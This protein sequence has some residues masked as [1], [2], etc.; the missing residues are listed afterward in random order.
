M[1]DSRTSIASEIKAAHTRIAEHYGLT[2]IHGAIPAP[3]YHHWNFERRAVRPLRHFVET[4]FRPD[5]VLL[6]DAG[7]GNGQ[8][9][10]LYLQLF[11]VPFV[12]GV[13]FS[14]A[15]LHMARRRLDSPEPNSRFLAVQA[16]LSD[17]SALR[18][19]SVDAVHLFGVIE[20]LDHPVL[21][22]QQLYRVLKKG[23]CMIWSVPR[24]WSLA[25]FD[26]LLFGQSPRRWG[27]QA[28][29]RDLLSVKDKL[30]FYRFFSSKDIACMLRA[31]PKAK[32]EARIPFAHF[33]VQGFPFAP[34]FKLAQRQYGYRVLDH[35]DAACKLWPW[36]G[37]EFCIVRKG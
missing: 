10:Q 36:P 33:H 9:S 13:D 5:G 22:L 8:F 11:Q 2:D 37:A 27:N 17:L 1:N 15:M 26:Y 35:L 34:I 7:C 19:E 20:H 28:T 32:L 18:S 25:F 16:E 4:Y 14:G 6:L 23:R 29:L 31:L 30:R 3:S 21:V 12:L 24:R